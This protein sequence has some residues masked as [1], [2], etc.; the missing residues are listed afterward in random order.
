MKIRRVSMVLTMAVVTILTCVA[1]TTR[2]SCQTQDARKG[3]N[4]AEKKDANTASDPAQGEHVRTPMEPTTK[5]PQHKETSTTPA[6]AEDTE[7]AKEVTLPFG[8]AKHPAGD[9]KTSVHASNVPNWKVKDMG[10]SVRF[11]FPTAV[12][13]YVWIKK[14]S[15]LNDTEKL[16]LANATATP[17]P[18]TADTP[19]K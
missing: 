16:A 19:K 3:Q 5:T 15:D 6:K 11:E 4:P 8:I 9:G 12:G 14:K 17:A 13:P 18:A 2:G 7:R 1:L 10:D